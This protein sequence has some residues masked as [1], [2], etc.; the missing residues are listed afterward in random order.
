VPARGNRGGFAAS[1][2][3]NVGARPCV[4]GEAEPIKTP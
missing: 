1:A 4:R 2:G 3:I